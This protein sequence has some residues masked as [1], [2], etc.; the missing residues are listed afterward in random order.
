MSID[1]RDETDSKV[2]LQPKW[3]ISGATKMLLV[4]GGSVIFIRNPGSWVGTLAFTPSL[5]TAVGWFCLVLSA[6]TSVSIALGLTIGVVQVRNET[7]RVRPVGLLP[8]KTR[9]DQIDSVAVQ[10]DGEV[11]V[12]AGAR[13]IRI[14]GQLTST[15][16]QVAA[17]INQARQ[18][19]TG[20]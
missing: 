12:Q 10:P 19:S 11:I 17:M 15:P 5:V 6:L 4:G 7:L 9:L 13:R 14:N 1:R 16:E 20:T 3:A 18:R 8:Q 2:T